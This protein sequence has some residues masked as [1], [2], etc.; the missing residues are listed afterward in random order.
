M[1]YLANVN[2]AGLYSAS[3]F[4]INTCQRRPNYC[5][6][7]NDESDEQASIEGLI[8]N[9]RSTN[10]DSTSTVEVEDSENTF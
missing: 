4:R 9:Q 3:Y 6:T 7:L 10:I 1:F 8:E 5:Q 2:Y